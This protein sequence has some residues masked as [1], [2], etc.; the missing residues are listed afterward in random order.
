MDATCDGSRAHI[1]HGIKFLPIILLLAISLAGGARAALA[2]TKPDASRPES[3]CEPSA[4]GSPYIPVD[5]WI[6]PA[7]MRLYSLGY[8]DN[9]FLGMRPWTRASVSHMLEEA[10]A[11]IEDADEE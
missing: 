10:G 7:V 8:I 2:Q 11:H 5:S 6:Y 9:V 3:V 1:A 4:L